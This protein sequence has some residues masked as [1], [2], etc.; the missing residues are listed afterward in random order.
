MSADPTIRVAIVDDQPLFASGLSMLIEAQPDMECVGT[1]INGQ[2]AVRLAAQQRPDIMLMDLRMPVMNGLDATNLIL[3]QSPPG[4][5]SQV[6]V[7]TTIQ[8]DEAVHLALKAGATAFLTKDATPAHVLE[9][10]RSANAERELPEGDASLRV[11]EDFAQRED[12]ADGR[13]L[14]ATLT[15]GE[16]EI[17]NR[18]SQG[19]SNAEISG[20]LFLSEATVKSHVRAILHKLNLRSR[21]QVVIFAYENGLI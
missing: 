13:R 14:V 20:L 11:V 6:I 15:P 18:V 8:K 19:L 12:P 3:A 7:L 16:V 2:E 5:S 4:G 10:I 9:A 1:A 21:V 17:F